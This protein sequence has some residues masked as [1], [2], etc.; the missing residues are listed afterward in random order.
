M[1]IHRA[2]KQYII[3]VFAQLTSLRFLWIF[4]KYLQTFIRLHINSCD[5]YSYQDFQAGTSIGTWH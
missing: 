4:P 1:V 2:D 5:V 3:A